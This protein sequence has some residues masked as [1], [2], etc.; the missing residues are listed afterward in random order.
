MKIVAWLQSE[1]TYALEKNTV[2]TGTQIPQSTVSFT[3]LDQGRD[4]I[5]KLI[6]LKSMKHTISICTKENSGQ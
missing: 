6:L 3:D 2:P 4:I 1:A 5:S